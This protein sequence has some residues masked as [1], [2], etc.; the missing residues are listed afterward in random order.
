MNEYTV[1]KHAI[2]TASGIIIAIVLLICLPMATCGGIAFISIFAMSAENLTKDQSPDYIHNNSEYDIFGLLY[3]V[4]CIA[5][6]Y[7]L[8]KT[9]K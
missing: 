7:F 9:K 2:G 8:T 6:I 4:F 5:I 3:I 1:E